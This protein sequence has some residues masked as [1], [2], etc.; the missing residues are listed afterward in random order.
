MTKYFIAKQLVFLH[1]KI[2]FLVGDTLT[3]MGYYLIPWA[4][5]ICDFRLGHQVLARL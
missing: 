2:I 5:A 4:P 3:N 1:Y